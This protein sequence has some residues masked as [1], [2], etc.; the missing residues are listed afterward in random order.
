MMQLA[1][2]ISIP[3]RLLILVTLIAAGAIILS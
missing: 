1:F 2:K 3:P